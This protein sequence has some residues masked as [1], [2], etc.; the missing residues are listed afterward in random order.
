MVMREGEGV[1]IHEAGPG[2]WELMIF[3]FLTAY[4]FTF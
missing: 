4:L 2:A 3:C 1:E